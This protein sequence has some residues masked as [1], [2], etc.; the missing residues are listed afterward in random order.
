MQALSIRLGSSST[1]LFH[2]STLK[3]VYK[4][5]S[6]TASIY[7]KK[8]FLAFFPFCFCS[9]KLGGLR[10]CHFT[11]P[12]L[13]RYACY[14]VLSN[15]QTILLIRNN[16]HY[17]KIDMLLNWPACWTCTGFLFFLCLKMYF[18]RMTPAW[19]SY[20]FYDLIT[21]LGQQQKSDK[22]SYTTPFPC[23]CISTV[24]NDTT[25]CPFLYSE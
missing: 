10:A 1:C 11:P 19:H 15:K 24:L 7:S 12:H 6:K 18:Y 2:L 21:F 8:T 13:M 20:L 9:A 23:T 14:F 25:K 22:D 5:R 3:S 16:I 4:Y 17:F